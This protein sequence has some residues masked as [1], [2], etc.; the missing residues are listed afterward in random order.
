MGMSLECTRWC[1]ADRGLGLSAMT[2][3]DPQLGP[4][5]ARQDT[6]HAT[7]PVHTVILIESRRDDATRERSDG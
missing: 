7:I 2:G 6:S 1:R 3:V 4:F 5:L